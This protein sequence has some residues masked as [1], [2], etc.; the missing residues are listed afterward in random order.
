LFEEYVINDF[1]SKFQIQENGCH[2]WLG[3]ILKTG[4][5]C[6]KILSKEN[7]AQNVTWAMHTGEFNNKL[8]IIQTCGNKLCINIE[9]LE[10]KTKIKTKQK[11]KAK[12]KRKNSI[13][14]E[15]IVSIPK[16]KSHTKKKFIIFENTAIC[17]FCD[18]EKPLN[19]FRYRRDRNKYYAKCIECENAY[20]KEYRENLTPEQKKSIENKHKVNYL[21]NIEKTKIK[22][23]ER[24]LKNIELY[25]EEYLEKKRE[26]VRKHYAENKGYYLSRNAKRRF[27]ETEGKYTAEELKTLLIKQNY[28]CNICMVFNNYQQYDNLHAD[29]IYPLSKGGSNSINNIQGLCPQHNKS[30]GTREMNEYLNEENF[31]KWQLLIK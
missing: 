12:T 23:K 17:N 18:I 20:F 14:H 13:H 19:C 8:K 29:H 3:S 28:R 27:V 11:R 7:K 2:I 31:K 16:K 4:F 30:K 5:G 24:Y 26:V 1:N 21:K 9:H 10:N 15:N 22:D 6:F 25:G